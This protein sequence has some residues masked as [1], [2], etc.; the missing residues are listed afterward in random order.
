[1]AQ[2]KRASQRRMYAGEHPNRVAALVDRGTAALAA[3]GLGPKRVVQLEVRGRCSG[4]RLTLPVVIADYAGHRYLV[5]MLGERA[6]WVRNVR[7][8]AGHAALRHGQRE[9]VTLEE[10]D[11]SMRGP[12]L[13]RYLELAPGA[14]AHFP[15]D[16]RDPLEKF[17]QI[18]AQYPVFRIISGEPAR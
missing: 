10:V 14:R 1:M 18:A 12:I 9:E 15:V 6:N 5:A 11:P 8:A 4:R 17:E 13:R 7:A 16:R 3:A 2:M